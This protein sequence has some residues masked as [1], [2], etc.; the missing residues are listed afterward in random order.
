MIGKK[1]CNLQ[2]YVL[3]AADSIIL[4]QI[5]LCYKECVKLST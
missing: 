2:Y 3:Y 5:S 1:I 4:S